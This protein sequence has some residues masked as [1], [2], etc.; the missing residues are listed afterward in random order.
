MKRLL[1]LCVSLMLVGAVSAQAG[2]LSDYQASMVTMTQNGPG[3]LSYSVSSYD[4][5]LDQVTVSLTGIAGGAAPNGPYIAVLEGVFNVGSTDG[6]G[7]FAADGSTGDSTSLGQLS[8][9]LTWI[10]ES[11]NIGNLSN[12]GSAFMTGPVGSPVDG[13]GIYTAF[14]D[15]YSSLSTSAMPRTNGT[16]NNAK[17]AVFY[18]TDATTTSVNFVDET[19]STYHSVVAFYGMPSAA[20]HFSIYVTPE[21]STIMLLASGLMGLLCYAWRKRK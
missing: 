13:L 10:N 15:T 3:Q 17:V 16:S 4:A 8:A 7:G 21:P 5:T 11:S 19:P 18:V 20:E 9:P 12:G 1:L 14:A 6:L 2:F